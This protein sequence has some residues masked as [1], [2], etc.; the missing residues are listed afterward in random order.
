MTLL[1]R[2]L[3]QLGERLAADYIS[4]AGLHVIDT[5]WRDGR[6]GELDIV[7]ADPTA[8]CYAVIEV[9]TR[10]GHQYGSG[11]ASVDMRKYRRL[12]ALAAAWVKTQE[13]QR[14]IRIDII[15]VTLNAAT[16]DRLAAG[17]SPEA[18]TCQDCEIMWVQGVAA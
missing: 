12:R 16:R 17:G 10:V 18:V 2:T 9:R 5:N 3:G 8:D 7:A 6:R 14:H 15:S 11:Y 4:E 1:R 13:S